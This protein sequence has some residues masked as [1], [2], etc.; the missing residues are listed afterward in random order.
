[1]VF[2]IASYCAL[3]RL[4]RKSAC[5][6]SLITEVSDVP[7]ALR[8]VRRLRKPP[9]F[10]ILDDLPKHTLLRWAGL[11]V[12][13]VVELYPLEEAYD[14]AAAFLSRIEPSASNR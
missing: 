9:R 13:Y 8:G 2:T 7:R 10:I 4:L 14:A 1:M 3:R 6:S 11:H 5:I 12:E